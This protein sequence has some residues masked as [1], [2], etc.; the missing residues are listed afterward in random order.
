MCDMLMRS[1]NVHMLCRMV[2]AAAHQHFG[3][4]A[5]IGAQQAVLDPP[6]PQ[7]MTGPHGNLTQAAGPSQTLAAMSAATG[8]TAPAMTAH[9]SDLRTAA[10]CKAYL[11]SLPG[12]DVALEQ[13]AAVTAS[14]NA[15]HDVLHQE[16]LTHLLQVGQTTGKLCIL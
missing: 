7:P 16:E 4:L 5:P 6:T 15:R 14:L 9:A 11:H 3:T 1:V 12:G 10:D 13:V 8:D 2:T